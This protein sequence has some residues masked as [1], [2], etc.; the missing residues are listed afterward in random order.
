[1]TFFN[2][3]LV[4]RLLPVSHLAGTEVLLISRQCLH[5]LQL[6]EQPLGLLRLREE[7]LQRQGPLGP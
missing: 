7:R 6:G 4:A 2:Q 5:H 3:A 1:M